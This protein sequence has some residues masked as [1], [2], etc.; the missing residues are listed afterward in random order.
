MRPP[1]LCAC[2]RAAASQAGARCSARAAHRPS[3]ARK[4]PQRGGCNSGG[5]APGAWVVRSWAS[6]RSLLGACSPQAPF[7]GVLRPIVAGCGRQSSGLAAAV[8]RAPRVLN[9]GSD[10]PRI[11][12]GALSQAPSRGAAW[13]RCR[14]AG[15]GGAGSCGDAKGLDQAERKASRNNP[16]TG[17]LAHLTSLSHIALASRCPPSPWQPLQSQWALPPPQHAAGP[18]VHPSSGAYTRRRQTRCG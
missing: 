7:P 8:C 12:L 4:R 11:A 15:G 13:E 18:A 9:T 16:T 1:P 10:G 2:C 17:A 14:C 5:P 6:P 3:P